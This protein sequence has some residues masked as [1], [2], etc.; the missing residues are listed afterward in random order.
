[1]CKCVSLCVRDLLCLGA[2]SFFF[3]SSVC[4]SV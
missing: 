2:C 3:I 4:V 1:M